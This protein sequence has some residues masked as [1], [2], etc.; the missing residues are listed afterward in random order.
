PSPLGQNNR[1]CC[2]VACPV[3][4]PWPIQGRSW[5]STTGGWQLHSYAH[6]GAWLFPLQQCGVRRS[7]V[8]ETVAMQNAPL[9]LSVGL[10]FRGILPQACEEAEFLRFSRKIC[11]SG[12][13][14]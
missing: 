1:D 13:W 4:G 9:S 3:D 2:P 10:H 11:V 6:A 8:L 14:I 5:P 7:V 12:V